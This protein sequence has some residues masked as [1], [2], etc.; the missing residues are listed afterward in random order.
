MTPCD[1]AVARF[2]RLTIIWY[3]LPAF[4]LAMP[5]IPLYVYL[6]TFYAET[7]GLGLTATGA[8]LLLARAIDVISDPLI[9][10]ASDRL[11][12]RSGRRRP[13]VLLG[14]VIAGVG[15]IRLLDPAEGADA[16]Y[17]AIWSVVLFLGWTLIAVPYSAW[18]AELSGDYAERARITGTREALTIAGVLAAGAAPAIA[19]GLGG[20]EA[21]GLAA[22]GWLAVATGLPAIL[23]LVWRVPDPLPGAASV[24]IPLRLAALEDLRANRPFVRLLS[25]WF[26]NG[27]ANG[28]PSVLFPLYVQYGLEAG[29]TMRGVLI[30]SYFLAGIGAIPLWV[31]L[32]RRFGKHRAWCFAMILACA[33]FIWVP[34]LG[35]GD[36]AA[37]F[38][39]CLVTGMALGAD[40]A[41]PPAMQAD[42]IDLDTFRTGQERA[43][44]FFALWSM[45]TKLALAA[46]VGVAFPALAAFGFTVGADNTAAA[47]LAL[48]VIYALV[49]T[50]LK[51]IAIGII[52]NHPIDQR[53]QSIIRRRL[54]SRARRRME[55]PVP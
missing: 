51:I 13:W 1:E 32:S 29:A 17:L 28:L 21:D 37:F 12:F 2:R 42:V 3:A 24:S 53:R 30:M 11:R 27:L 34:V 9:G 19:A 45:S 43:G 52:W 33:A 26:I 54:A 20:S 40:M 39:I 38:V 35:P 55:V 14:A 10:I 6:P 41:L 49:P 15:L 46:S 4:A 48:A 31:W 50:V 44:L 8:A 16:T 36:T 18:G 25:G 5:T 22:V 47:L 7:L 23:L